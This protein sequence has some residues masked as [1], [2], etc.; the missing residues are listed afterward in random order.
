LIYEELRGFA[1]EKR[2]PIWSAS[3]SN[4]EGSSADVV[5]LSNMSE[6]YGKAMVADVVVSISRKAH[7]KAG[8]FG[9]LFVAKNRAGRDGLLFPIRIDTSKSYFEILGGP[10]NMQEAIAEDEQ[11]IKNALR[12]KWNQMRKDPELGTDI[13]KFSLENSSK[14]DDDKKSDDGQS[15]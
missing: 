1:N 5:D 15:L 4:K 8:G 13:K 7:E 10:G 12:D 14:K 2:L 6:A 11:Q 3:Q 9:R